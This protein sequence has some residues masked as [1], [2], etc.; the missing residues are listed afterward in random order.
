MLDL[1]FEPVFKEQFK[2]DDYVTVVST[3][4]YDYNSSCRYTRPVIGK[5]YKIY[6]VSTNYV[7]LDV[8]NGIIA[9]K[10]SD[11][12][13]ATEEEIKKAQIQLPTINGKQCVDNGNKTITCG[14]TTKSFDWILGVEYA[15]DD[16][17]NISDT[18]V[19]QKEIEQIVEYINN[20]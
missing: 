14:C 19:T 4:T 20:K 2:K 18:K 13:K 8:P 11:L 3:G 5:I 15:M 16:Y 6:S 1:W 17:V 12:R 10:S 7:N 9:I